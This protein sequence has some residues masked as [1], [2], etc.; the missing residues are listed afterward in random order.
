MKIFK[1]IEKHLANAGLGTSPYVQ[2]AGVSV[3]RSWIRFIIFSF[4]ALGSVLEGILC[5][6]G[7]G[8]SLAV[9]LWSLCMMLTFLSVAAIYISLV[10]KTKQ[11]NKLFIYLDNLIVASKF[12]RFFLCLKLK[13]VNK[14]GYLNIFTKGSRSTESSVIYTTR[15]E[16]TEKIIRIIFILGVQTII[17]AN[18]IPALYP[19]LYITFGYPSP[20]LWFTPFQLHKVLVS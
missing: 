9:G 15:N 16:I 12:F 8:D 14:I 7:S 4:T 1:A 2:I 17:M 18:S 11:I 5:I 6:N 10:M 19:V 20:D 13:K 3:R